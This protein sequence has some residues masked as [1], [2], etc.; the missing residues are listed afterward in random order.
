MI[1]WFAVGLFHGFQMD[2]R[3][4]HKPFSVSANFFQPFTKPAFTAALSVLKNTR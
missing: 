1:F 2:K 4:P 3:E